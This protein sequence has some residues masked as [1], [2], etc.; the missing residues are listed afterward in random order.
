MLLRRMLDE[1]EFLSDYGVRALSKYHE[2]HPY[3]FDCAGVTLA[4]KYLPAESDSRVFGGNSNWRGPI[5]FPVNYLLIESLQKFHHY[6]GD[7]FKIECPTG[8]GNFVTIEQVA[9]ELTRR[10][11]RIFLRD[12]QGRRAVFGEQ[13]KLQHDPNFQGP[14]AV[15][16]V[17]PRRQ[18]TWA[19]ALRTRPAG[20][21]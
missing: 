17:L 7:D 14:R 15:L 13:P 18:R 21:A 12:E 20:P 5:W 6:Y 8:S 19:W 10:L 9:E 11:S 4:V 3:V 16:R 2:A 1:S